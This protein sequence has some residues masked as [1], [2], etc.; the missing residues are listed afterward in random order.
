MA[1]QVGFRVQGL[2]Q[3]VKALQEFGLEVDDLKDVF[4]RIASEGAEAA[5]R[6]AP[7]KTGRL[8]SDIRGNRAKAK[9]VVTAGRKSVPYAGPI[10]Y[11]WP[12][13]GIAPTQFLQAADEEMRPRAIQL[14]EDGINA[15]IRKKGLT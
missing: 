3:V 10:N 8:R 14:L 13:R 6:H 15:Q 2:T 11:G 7:V 4:S 1:Q 5:A 12:R 9:A